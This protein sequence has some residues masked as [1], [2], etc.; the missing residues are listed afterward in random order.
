MNRPPVVVR[1]SPSAA[2]K[3]QSGCSPEPS[4]TSTSANASDLDLLERD[5]LLVR[6]DQAK[7]E[8]DHWIG[9]ALALGAGPEVHS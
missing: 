4:C 9:R 3:T 7:R 8:R 2:L 1:P 6:L 5:E